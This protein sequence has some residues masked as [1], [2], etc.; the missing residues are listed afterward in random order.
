MKNKHIFLLKNNKLFVGTYINA[1]WFAGRIYNFLFS[2]RKPQPRNYA[3]ASKKIFSL[4]SRMNMELFPMFGTLL[5]IYRDKYL[6]YADDFDFAVIGNDK[7]TDETIRKFEELRFSLFSVSTVGEKNNLVELTFKMDGVKVDLFKLQTL[8]DGRI[9]HLC[10]NF[11]KGIC[12][13]K[14]KNGLKIY[15]YNS[16]FQVNYD[17]FDLVYDEKF[18]IKIPSDPVH[19]FET[20]YG[21]D[22]F[23]PKQKNF[24]DYKKYNFYIDPSYTIE[25]PSLLLKEYLNKNDLLSSP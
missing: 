5:S 21:S 19:I 2:P 11:R 16:Y 7:F 24:I 25:G 3:Y 6:L 18:G 15:K 12:I 4:I 17:S 20:H 8:P 10:P 22:W 13:K 23:I 1:T 14:N 9:Q